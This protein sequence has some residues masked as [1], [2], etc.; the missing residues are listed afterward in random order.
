M[1]ADRRSGRISDIYE[2]IDFC[3]YILYAID[4]SVSSVM[5]RSIREQIRDWILQRIGTGELVPGDRLTETGIA[6]QLGVSPIP[7]REAIRELVT[8]GILGSAVHKGAWVR[9]V[10][11]AETIEALR[12]R[13]VLEALALRLAVPRL[14][15][16]LDELRRVTG[17]LEAVAS[18][19]DLQTFQKLNHQFHRG[20]IEASGSGVLLRV[21]DSLTYEV[22]AQSVL[23]SIH[24]VSAVD[25]AK[26]HG[27]V[28]DA[29]EQ[30][31]VTR[32]ERLLARHT[33]SLAIRLE[34][35]LHMESA[36]PP[37]VG[38]RAAS[39]KRGRRNLQAPRR[40]PTARV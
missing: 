17:E 4:M 7:V 3:L 37:T 23:Q 34:K 22:N 6:E 39:S 21:W 25:V 9:K 30:G 10:E 36:A 2:L 15:E 26:E 40:S 19:G 11:V 35:E 12:V 31:A 8:V 28:L 32:A 1:H 29:V 13:A 14:H 24:S 5:A 20:I 16:A 27:A 38:K 33:E 18:R